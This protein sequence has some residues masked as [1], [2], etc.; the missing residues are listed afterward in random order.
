VARTPRSGSGCPRT[1]ECDTPCATVRTRMWHCGQNG[2]RKGHHTR[3]H[4]TMDA[5][6]ISHLISHIVWSHPVTKGCKHN[7]PDNVSQT[8]S[9]SVNRSSSTAARCSD[10]TRDVLLE[11]SALYCLLSVL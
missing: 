5:S 2:L 4:L 8:Q 10:A 9:D 6:L 1:L 11:R 3:T 7:G